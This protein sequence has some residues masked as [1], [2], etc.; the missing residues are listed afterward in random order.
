MNPGRLTLR[1][2][3]AAALVA[4]AAGLAVIAAFG[5]L[6]GLLAAAIVLAAA[7][8]AVIPRGGDRSRVLWWMHPAWALV[9]AIL[10]GLALTTILPEAT[11]LDQWRTPKFLTLDLALLLLALAATFVIGVILAGALMA[12]RTDAPSAL[13]AAPPALLPVLER[14]AVVLCWLTV[15]GYVLWACVGVA[16]GLRPGDLTLAVTGEVS[17]LKDFLTPIGG[18][19]TLTQFGPVAAVVLILARHLGSELPALRL[20]AMLVALSMLRVVGYA[21]R[22][23]VLEVVLPALLIWLVLPRPRRS[24]RIALT[25]LPVWAPVVLVVFFGTFEYV[26]SYSSDY[27]QREYA[28]RSYSEFT[29]M[30][31]GAYYA[32]GPNNSALV[33]RADQR[34]RDIPYY[35]LSGLWNVAPVAA[36]APYER[37]AGT[38]QTT[39]YRELLELEANA[40]YNNT[41]GLI[42]PVFDYGLIGGFIFWLG[43]GVAVGAAYRLFTTGDVRGLILYPVLYFG[44]LE[45]GLIFYWTTGR[46]LPSIVAALVV[47]ARA[48]QALRPTTPPRPHRVSMPHT[49][50]SHP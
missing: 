20:L 7:I 13:A 30:R 21:E 50:P 44:L 46:A 14:A 9:L 48:H 38:S 29:L 23:A 10:P 4:A 27:Y 1:A 24:R 35:T 2:A 12:R 33:L 45:A 22:L 47:G 34:E 19:T 32:T 37:F 28:G 49:T 36:F 31:L 16:R 3:G 40:E 25:L 11:F 17:V 15:T 6:V 8:L 42:L 26:R 43:A 5:G 18:V 39:D 41:G